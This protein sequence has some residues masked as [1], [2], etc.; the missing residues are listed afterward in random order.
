MTLFAQ[1]VGRLRERGLSCALIGAEALALRGVSRATADRDLLATDPRALEPALWAA[2]GE[3]GVRVEIRR[4]DAEDPLAGVVRFAADGERP[5]DLVVGRGGWQTRILH[6]APL[7]DLGEVAV[8]VPG[9]A[10]LVLLKLYAG[11]PQD[12]WDIAQLLNGDDREAVIDEVRER[13]EE[14]P[15]DCLRLWESLLPA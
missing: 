6:R 2:L 5:V 4:G 13:L 3:I 14:L 7:L 15:A 1:V 9:A 10:D 12:A 11:G 8:A